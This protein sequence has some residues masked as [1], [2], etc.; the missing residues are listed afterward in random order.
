MVGVDQLD[1]ADV[2][3]A[4]EQIGG[5]PQLPLIWGHGLSSSMESEDELGLI[6][7]EQAAPGRL[8]VRYDARGHGASGSTPEPSD[9]VWDAPAAT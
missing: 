3:I 1:L 8:V 2:T 9:Y 5:G 4:H 7:W 6:D